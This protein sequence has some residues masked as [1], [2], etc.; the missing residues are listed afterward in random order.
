MFNVFC[1]SE[2]HIQ[3]KYGCEFFG[4]NIFSSVQPEILANLKR[5]SGPGAGGPGRYPYYRD[6]EAPGKGGAQDVPFERGGASLFRSCVE[7]SVQSLDTW[8]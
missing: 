3:F 4:L 7:V 6:A 5:L 1:S 2:L 8:F